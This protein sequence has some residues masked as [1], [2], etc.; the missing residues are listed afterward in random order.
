MGGVRVKGGASRPTVESKANT[1][2]SR[3]RGELQAADCRAST[4]GANPW[5][6]RVQMVAAYAVLGVGLTHFNGSPGR[7]E[8]AINIVVAIARQWVSEEQ[9]ERWR[10]QWGLLLR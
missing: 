5:R 10:P 8:E 6:W 3:T 1:C 9:E 2:K 4:G 7:A